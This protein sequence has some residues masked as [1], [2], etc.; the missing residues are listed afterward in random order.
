MSSWLD[1]IGARGVWAPM[2]VLA[3]GDAVRFAARLEELGYGC[4]WVPETV[5]RDPFVHIAHLAGAAPDLAF[6]TGIANIHHRHPGVMLQAANALAE[7]T[8]GRFVLGVGVSHQPLV[9]GLRGL[10]YEKPLRAMRTY[11][12]TMASAPYMAP[13]PA[14]RVP[15]LVAA[16]GPRMLELAATHADGAHPYWTTPEHTA[17]ARKA[18]GPDRAL[19]VEQKVVLTEDADEAR[20][21]A[22]G[23]L[24]MYVTL[25]NYRNNWLRLGFTDAEIDGHDPRFLDAV[26]A[27]GSVDAVEARLREH[28]DA[29]ADHVCIQAMT[30]GHPFR[31]DLDALAAL[32]PS[33]R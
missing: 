31:P 1:R 25:P 13:A 2:D 6:A 7:Q 27:W 12:E 4:L 9:S 3:L 14:E 24:A 8:G 30:P 5:G 33:A 26:V 20:A 21:T 10:P 17:I 32:A 11:L 15:V 23:A 18:L 29:G 19:C 22:V 16:L 28:V